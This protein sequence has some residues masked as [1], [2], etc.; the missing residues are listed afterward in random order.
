MVTWLD[1]H[2]KISTKMLSPHTT[3]G[4][5][6]VI[7]L[8]NRAHGL[9]SFPSEVSIEVGDYISRGTTRLRRN[10]DECS[11]CSGCVLHTSNEAFI[12]GFCRGKERVL[13]ERKDGWLELEL[14]EFYHD[15]SEK[16]VKM[17]LKEIY[18]QHIKGGIIVEGIELR[19]K[20]I[21]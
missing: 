17:C 4:A 10:V 11:I 21:I 6:L 2:G 7:K 1:I 8:A 13:N 9:H 19:P 5:Y 15:G 12:P 3:Y 20:L 16:E 14:G 18:G